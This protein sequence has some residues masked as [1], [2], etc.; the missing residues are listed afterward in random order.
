MLGGC[1]LDGIGDRA[2]ELAADGQTRSRR[3]TSAAPTRAPI[4]ACVGSR[5]ISTVGMAINITE[6]VS[7]RL[8]PIRSPTWPNRTPRSG[9]A[10][11]PTANTAK[12]AS[13]DEIR[14]AAGKKLAPM[15]HGKIAVDRE[16]VPFHDVAD[17]AGGDDPT[18]GNGRRSVACD[19]SRSKTSEIARC[20][21]HGP[22]PPPRLCS[23][24]ARSSQLS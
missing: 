17:E 24:R 20:Q 22:F 7:A 5:P 16:I 13:V 19:R 6:A 21:A 2:G 18:S 4:Y 15:G 3:N 12:A 8:R 1:V 11:K 10:R 9:R 23:V 14:S